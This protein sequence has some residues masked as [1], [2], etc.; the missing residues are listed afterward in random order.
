MSSMSRAPAWAKSLRAISMK[1]GT[2]YAATTETTVSTMAN[3][4]NVKPLAVEVIS[5]FPCST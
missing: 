2:M 5:A 4:T 1:S 3:S